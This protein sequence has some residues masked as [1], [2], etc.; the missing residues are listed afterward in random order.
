MGGRGILSIFNCYR[1]ECTAVANYIQQ[2]TDPLT[3][4][5][6]EVEAPKKTGILSYLNN[7]KSGTT[8]IITNESAG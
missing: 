5:I 3:I 4:I 7:N 2:S 6:K 8:D 1:Q